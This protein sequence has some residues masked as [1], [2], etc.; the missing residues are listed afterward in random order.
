MTVGSTTDQ[1]TQL[2]YFITKGEAYFRALSNAY[3]GI[4]F[5]LSSLLINY[6]KFNLKG[7]VENNTNIVLY[8]GKRNMNIKLQHKNKNHSPVYLRMKDDH[9]TFQISLKHG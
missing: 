7:L 8:C 5:F 9:N 4:M 2:H 6:Y 3:I 1:T